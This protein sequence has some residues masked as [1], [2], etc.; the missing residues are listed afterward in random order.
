[1]SLFFYQSRVKAKRNKKKWISR[2]DNAE[3]KGSVQLHS[4]VWLTLLC[5][6]LV[7]TLSI[8][9]SLP[10]HLPPPLMPSSSPLVVSPRPRP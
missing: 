3:G 7:P 6:Y 5:L 9:Y 8:P 2:K 10:P 1:M 4:L